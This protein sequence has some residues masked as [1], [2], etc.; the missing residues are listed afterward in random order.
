MGWL[1][2][3]DYEECGLMVM[4]DVEDGDDMYWEVKEKNEEVEEEKNDD[5][6]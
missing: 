3:D 4:E 2:E 1:D 5:D 6:E